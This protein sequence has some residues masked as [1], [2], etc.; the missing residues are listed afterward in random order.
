MLKELFYVK[1]LLK[2]LGIILLLFM[3]F[4]IL[5]LVFNYHLFPTISI[6]EFLTIMLTGLRFDISAI[7]YMYLVF[8]LLA[9]LP[10]PFRNKQWYKILVKLCFYLPTL[11]ILLLSTADLIYYQFT[12]KRT[13][14]D[15]LNMYKEFINLLPQ[16]LKD[17]WYLFFI[18]LITLTGIEIV[19]RKTSGKGYSKLKLTKQ[20]IILIIV[21]LLVFMGAR[22]GIQ[23]RPLSPIMAGK[24]AGPDMSPLVTNTPFN[25][26]YSLQHK[27]LDDVSYFNEKELKNEYTVLHEGDGEG[28]QDNI[29]IIIMESFSK[30]YIG[31]LNNGKGYTPFLDSLIDQGL[32]CTNFYAN[33]KQSVQGIASIT[34]SIPALMTEPFIFSIYQDHKIQ[35]LGTLLKNMGYHTAFFHGGN[36]GTMGFDAFFKAA[37]VDHYY[38]KNEYDNKQHYDGNWGIYDEHFFQYTAREINKFPQPFCAILF[39]LSSHNPYNIP[40]EYE[41]KFDK[42]KLP[43]HQSIRYADYS[44]KRFFESASQMPWFDNTLF[45]ITADHTAQAES[46]FYKNRV[47]SYQIPLLLY[48]HNSR[49][50]GRN[51]KTSQQID[52]MPTIL[53]YVGYTGKYVAFG[54]SMLDST[55][56]GYAFQYH[57]DIFQ[58]IDSTHILLFD[59]NKTIAF[60]N[61][62]ED[63]LL[64]KN[65]VDNQSRQQKVMEDYLKAVIQTHHQA[66]IKNQLAI[67]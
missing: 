46:N 53:D 55:S 43:I 34:A 17:F 3:L 7:T 64:N 59:G 51:E 9:M 37:G 19:Y 48:K 12:L 50:K 38:G 21:S 58:I 32:I 30:E 31:T 10:F 1:Q 23:Y 13:T 57:N 45:I 8:I 47:G 5:F 29:L 22:G 14:I 40:E 26:I 41:D 27:T 63:S 2:R 28:E 39:S 24:Y 15:V 33:G 62:K 65:I 35:G 25:F 11:L 49:L 6:V 16:F 42:G 44:L 54:K 4:R 67:E 61:Y 36:N 52:I 56:P 18:F 20:S 66:L 60:Y